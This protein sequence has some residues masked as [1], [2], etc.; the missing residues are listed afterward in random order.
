VGL[1]EFD[2]GFR[3]GLARHPPTVLAAARV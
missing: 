3:L 2:E 1:Q